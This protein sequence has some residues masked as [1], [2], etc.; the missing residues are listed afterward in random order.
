MEKQGKKLAIISYITILGSLVAMSM[1]SENKNQ[2]ASFHIRQSLGL[3]LSFFLLGYLIAMFDNFGVTFGFWTFFF[4]L[5]IFG[6]SGA[7]QGK[8][9]LIPILGTFFQKI[10]K[11]L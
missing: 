4:I 7:L 11:S 2:F 9:Q 8:L 5:W 3:N 10:F 1:N 6:F